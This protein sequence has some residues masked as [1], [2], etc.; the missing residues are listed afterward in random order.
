MNTI[1]AIATAQASA[2]IG[3]VRISGQKAIEIADKVFVS[4]SG[5][6][7]ASRGGYCAALGHV[8]D[9]TTKIDEAIAL[10]FRAPKSYTGE[11]VVELS[12]HGGPYIMS[13]I[14]R[15]VLSAGAQPAQ[16]GEFTQRAFLNGKIDLSRAEAIMG[17]IGAKGEA[18]RE[19]TL[20]V[21]DGSLSKEIKSAAAVLTKICAHLAVWADYPEE[22]IPE[23]SDEKLFKSL[24]QVEKTLKKLLD[25]FDAGRA[26]I[27]GVDTVI[28]GKPN[29]GKST[30]LNVLAGTEKAIVTPEAGT[31][32]DI[33]EETVRVENTTLRL[34]DT[35]GIHEEALSEIEKIGIQR[36]IKRMQRA[37]LVIVVLENSEELTQGELELLKKAAMKKCVVAV[38]K[39][40]K[41]ARLDIEQVKAV[42]ENIAF[43]SAS[44]REGIEELNSLILRVLG[45]ADFDTSQPV[46][47]TERQRN[48]VSKAL[49]SVREALDALSSE[50]TRDAVSVSL[51]D[52][53]SKLLELTGENASEAVVNEVF[54]SF[55]V[56][57]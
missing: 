29:V 49:E 47:I 20:N 36:A 39:T 28:V 19:A 45:T 55:C 37:Q 15:A 32:R 35:A 44:R 16:P 23:L 11:D 2:G 24:R 25:S 1:A 3:I 14:L 18:A 17:L 57:K 22:D 6:P 34:A 33:I 30:L 48:C 10:L 46:I 4:A 43:I 5:K 41:K 40:D 38:N 13:R 51:D 27:E 42:T 12:G 54:R 50:V 8:Y 53:V 56:G 21:L 26:V 7:L 9:G 31:T 52:A